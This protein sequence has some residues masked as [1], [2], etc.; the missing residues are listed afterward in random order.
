MVKEIEDNELDSLY[1]TPKKTMVSPRVYEHIVEGMRMAVTDGTCRAANIPGLDVC[2]KT[3]T[4]QNKG[5]DHSAFMGF[6][7][8]KNPR[9]AVAVYVENGGFGATFGVPIGALL[10]EKYLTGTL[11]EESIQKAKEIENR[12]IYYGT[13]ER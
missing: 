13:E 4:A 10:M 5:K 2:G 7:P 11:S 8:M 6:A 9:I 1:L 12:T 3:G